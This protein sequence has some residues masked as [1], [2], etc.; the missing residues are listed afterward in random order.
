A[1][2]RAALDRERPTGPAGLGTF[3][4]QPASHRRPSCSRYHSA[5]RHRHGAGI[6]HRARTPAHDRRRVVPPVTHLPPE[7]RGSAADRDA[8]DWHALLAGDPGAATG[9]HAAASGPATGASPAAGGSTGQPM[10]RREARE[11]EAR[12]AEQRRVAVVEPEEFAPAKHSRAE[13]RAAA[14]ENNHHD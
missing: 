3:E 4:S 5:T 11:A 2:G 7:S 12:A 9:S 10:T 6:G 13:R 14:S 8:V 1:G